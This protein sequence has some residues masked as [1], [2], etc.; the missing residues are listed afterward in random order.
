MI[1]HACP[2]CH[3]TGNVPGGFYNCCP[4]G[5]PVSTVSMEKCRSCVNGMVWENET[6]I[7]IQTV[8]QSSGSGIC[9]E[10]YYY[11]N[12]RSSMLGSLVLLIGKIARF[13]KRMGKKL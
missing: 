3:G 12:E 13:F 4:G 9:K 7:T 1:P 6:H 11:P 10:I 5:T 8:P 2:I